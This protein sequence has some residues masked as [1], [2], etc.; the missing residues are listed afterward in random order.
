LLR[1]DK[2]KRTF[3][4][5]AQ[6]AGWQAFRRA[7][8]SRRGWPTYRK[9]HTPLP[10]ATRLF[11][12]FAETQPPVEDRPLARKPDQLANDEEQRCQQHKAHG[13]KAILHDVGHA[14]HSHTGVGRWSTQAGEP[15][16]QGCVFDV[17]RHG[18]VVPQKKRHPP[19]SAADR[20]WERSCMVNGSIPTIFA[21]AWLMRR[22]LGV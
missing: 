22:I 1:L 3:Q 6:Q 17:S 10:G 12:I 5:L 21:L 8:L 2:G 16:R 14:A 13:G 7:E 9:M 15:R 11:P 4:H 20:I 19:R 18:H